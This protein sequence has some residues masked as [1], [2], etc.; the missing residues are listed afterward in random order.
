M[1]EVVFLGGV[2]K[3]DIPVDRVLD[4]AKHL[5]S[6]LVLGWTKDGEFY[7]GTSNG[8][9]KSEET[10]ALAQRFVH[11]YYTGDYS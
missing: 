4:A 5:E 8:A 1:G 3:L 2:T 7:A 11:K 9:A 10:V 6:V